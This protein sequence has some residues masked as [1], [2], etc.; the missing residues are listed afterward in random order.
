MVDSAGAG[1]TG[2]NKGWSVGTPQ[3]GPRG[4]MAGSVAGACPCPWPYGAVLRGGLLRA[5]SYWAV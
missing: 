3:A 2:L 4:Q 5:V 1:T